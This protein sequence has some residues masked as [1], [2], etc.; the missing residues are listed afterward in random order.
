MMLLA[1]ASVWSLALRRRHGAPFNQV[2]L[3]MRDELAES[4]RGG[5]VAMVGPIRQELLSGI[6]DKAQFQETKIALGAF[7][8]EPLGTP[9]YE[10]AAR[11]HN[12]C[13]RQGLQCG[14]VDILI[15]AVARRRSW[16]VSTNDAAMMRCMEALATEPA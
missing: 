6:G 15:L 16:H 2:E 12:I 13:R 1:D 11:L 3:R 8:D 10:E 4:I 7:R 9:D 5:R 14:P